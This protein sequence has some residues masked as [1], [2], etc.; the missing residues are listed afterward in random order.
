[1]QGR[2]SWAAAT[3]RFRGLE[4]PR[5]QGQE[6]EPDLFSPAQTGREYQ[7]GRAEY[8]DQSG[9]A[10]ATRRATSFL[11]IPTRPWWQAWNSGWSSS[12]SAAAPALISR[13]AA[14][15]SSAA[16]AAFSRRCRA[17]HSCAAAVSARARADGP[18]QQQL[19][20][21]SRPARGRCCGG[22]TDSSGGLAEVD[23]T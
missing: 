15:S 21:R 14:I 3:Q 13:S 7:P 8:Q 20:A 22:A 10:T 16:Q 4:S 23:G 5:H 1:M 17:H 18:R 6:E 9:G 19:A 2:R 11:T 12:H